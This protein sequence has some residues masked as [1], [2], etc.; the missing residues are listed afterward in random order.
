MKILAFNGSPR[1]K[2]NTAT[3]L[4]NALD[5][6]ASQGAETELI[7]LYD[8]HYT[9]CRSCFACKLIGGKSY[10]RCALKDELAPILDK[11]HEADALIFGSPIYVGNLSAGMRAF[12][13]RLFYQYAMYNDTMAFHRKIPTGFIYTMN[14]S[15]ELL[16][17]A[18]FGQ[19]FLQSAAAKTFGGPV[20]ALN[21][22]DT[23]QFDDYSKYEVTMFDV[24]A[25][26][27]RREEQFPI[28]C[29]DA[30]DMGVRIAQYCQKDDFSDIPMHLHPYFS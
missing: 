11:A 27:K 30:F 16:K 6:A 9:G 5:G 23:Y 3:L 4:R 18:D 13:E 8:Y 26:K 29:Q 7:H 14:V 15:Q 20:E 2:W 10:G 12:L 28:D 24:N 25:K 22:T 21:V 17:L 19:E 1:K